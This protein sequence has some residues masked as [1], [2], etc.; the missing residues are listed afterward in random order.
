MSAKQ[1]LSENEMAILQEQLSKQRRADVSAWEKTQL[2]ASVAASSSAFAHRGG[3]PHSFV[4]AN[5]TA[6][7]HSQGAGAG[8]GAVPST[9]WNNM[10][11]AAVPSSAQSG[12][13]S[14]RDFTVAQLK[15]LSEN[16]EQKQLECSSKIQLANMLCQT[17][18][19]GATDMQMLIQII[20]NMGNA[21][22]ERHTVCQ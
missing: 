15:T 4:R 5:N 1:D 22:Q 7:P 21:I 2:A 16:L 3:S 19:K 17:N 18:D 20:M 14:P 8:A 13:A 6:S 11:G 9:S 12:F 10:G